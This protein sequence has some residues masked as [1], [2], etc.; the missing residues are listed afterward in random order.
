MQLVFV[1]QMDYIIANVICFLVAKIT[2]VTEAIALFVK[3]RNVLSL[4]F[5]KIKYEP[6]I[7]LA[8]EWTFQRY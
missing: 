5:W 4:W 8:A 3:Y 6:F 7:K 1:L 2:L